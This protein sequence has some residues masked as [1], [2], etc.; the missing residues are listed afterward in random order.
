MVAEP[1][2]LEF[3]YSRYGF[4]NEENYL[5][6]AP[7][8]LTEEVVR[9]LSAMKEEPEWMLK[10]RLKALRI[11]N[12]KPTPVTGTWA[13]PELANL[14]HDQI[15]Y[16]VRAGERPE[17][18]WDAVPQEIKDTFEKLGIPEAERNF[19]AG[20][21]AQYESEV[22]YHS[23]REEWSNLGVVF[24][25]TDTALKEY[26]ELFK[27]YF[28]TVIPAADNKYAAL[29]TAVWSGGSFVYI[30]AGVNVDI[31]LQAYF[32]I[33]AENMGQFER[34]LIIVEEGAEAHYIEGCTAPVY[35]SNSLHSA[36][37]EIVVK[38]GARFRYTTIQNW[39]NNIYNLVTKRAIAHE[40]ASMEWVDGNIGSRLTMKYP[41][42]Y[43][44]GRG[45]RGEVL[46]VAYAGKGQHQDA[47]AKMVHIA[48]ETTSRITNKSVS[49]DGGKTTYRGLAKVAPGAYN[50][51]I[52]VECDA[53]ILDEHSSSDT[54]PYIEIE[55]E[56]TTLAHEATVGKIGDE[57][58]FYLMSR[59]L[60]EADAMSMIVLGFME[61]FTRELPMEY[62]IE[63]NRLI[64]LEMEG[65]VG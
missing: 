4:R 25:D 60:S 2:N 1:V 14:D 49:K 18:D 26:P 8:G 22:V 65:S 39:A 23:L 13:N 36:V 45:A 41:S 61:P 38:K 63:L 57:Q 6:K 48:P 40:D 35:S 28:G 21:G 37:V 12:Q 42:V 9:E 53:L 16:F 11:F 64:Q 32:R 19:L 15:H 5:Y 44:M 52:N 10:R 20:V 54:I 50:S 24:L 58:L 62:A 34:T 17:N 43:L 59:G 47:G 27:Q 33:N 7:K 55:E 56:R 3:D 51:K 46:S 29:N 30:P 31:P